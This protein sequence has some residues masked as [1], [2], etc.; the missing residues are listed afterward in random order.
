MMEKYDGVRVYWDGKQ[1]HIKSLN[2]V[3]NVPKEASFPSTPFE[4][5]FW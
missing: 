3:T 1:L 4:G 2:V 5:E